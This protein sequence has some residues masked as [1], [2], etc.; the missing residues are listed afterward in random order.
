MNSNGNTY[1]DRG[2]TREK[3]SGEQSSNASVENYD[4]QAKWHKQLAR[5]AAIRAHLESTKQEN[6]PTV[7]HKQRNPKYAF[8]P[9]LARKGWVWCYDPSRGRWV[10]ER[11]EN[12]HYPIAYQ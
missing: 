11:E 3:A 8:I 12:T 1:T 6:P 10:E 2:I 9:R 7:L 5:E 4:L